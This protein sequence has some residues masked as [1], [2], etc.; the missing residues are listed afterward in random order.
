M[1]S[2]DAMILGNYNTFLFYLGFVILFASVFPRFLS[3]H[4]ITAPVAYLVM[5]VIIFSILPDMQ[6][7]HLAEEPYLGKRLTEFGVIISLTGAGLKLKKPFVWLTWK[8]ALRLLVFTLP[9]TIGLIAFMGWQFW[10]FAPAT[11]L[12]LG[13][14]TAPTD[15]VLASEIQTTPPH[16]DDLSSSRLALTAEA[17]LNDGLAFP[18]TNMAITIALLGTDT[19]LWLSDWFMTDFLYKIFVGAIVGLFTGWLLAKI[20]FCC[21]KPQS[22]NSA[23]SVGLLTL[24][25]TLL[26][27][28][29]GELLHSYG[30]ISV[31]LA[32]CAFRYQENT[33]EYLL[34]LHNFSEEIESIMIVILFTLAG[35]YISKNFM[36]DFQWYMVPASLI[37]ILIIRPLTG[38]LSLIGAK[39]PTRKKFI[40]SFF[41]I[42]GIGSAYYLLY[43]FYH[44]DFPQAKQALALLTMVIVLSVFIHGFTARPVMKRWAP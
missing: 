29:L 13:A 44:A 16:L 5:A 3:H 43:A 10:G 18:F 20:I 39:L 36:N 40:I 1:N 33:H 2:F 12:L 32:A 42:R 11:A 22:H 25:L 7:P 23:V 35:I 37:I 38:Y 6:I 21:P 9:L 34:I 15:P 14:V 31:F 26:P 41:G 19:S 17:G 8:Y 28:A 24:S 27:Y 4:I 30:F